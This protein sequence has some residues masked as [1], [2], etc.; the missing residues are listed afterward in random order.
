MMHPVRRLRGV[1]LLASVT[2]AACS[3]GDPQPRA[4]A[5]AAATSAAGLPEGHPAI[6]GMGAPGTAVTGVVKET[7]D[8]GGYTFA[9][10]DLGDRESWVAGPETKLGVGEARALPDTMNMGQFTASSLDRTFDVLYFTSDFGTQAP[11][12][13]ASMEFQGTVK[14]TMNAAGYTYALVEADGVAIWLAAPETVLSIGE[15]VVWNG[16]MAMKDFHSNTLDR[17]F[18]TIYFVEDIKP[19]HPGA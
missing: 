1:L 11:P 8:G 13:V 16:G 2:A 19:A 17:T 4:Q 9:L 14:E 15:S 3:P 12:E 7:M 6:G 5:Q 10:L 18:E